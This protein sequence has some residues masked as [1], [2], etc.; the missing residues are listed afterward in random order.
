MYTFYKA[1]LGFP[2]ILSCCCSTVL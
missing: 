1:V 2:C